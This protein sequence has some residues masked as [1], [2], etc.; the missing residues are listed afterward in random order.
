[1]SDLLDTFRSVAVL[2]FIISLVL[3]WITPGFNYMHLIYLLICN[4]I[5]WVYYFIGI[6][7]DVVEKKEKN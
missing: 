4:T 2:L 3:F 7:G 6:K 5:L 1:M